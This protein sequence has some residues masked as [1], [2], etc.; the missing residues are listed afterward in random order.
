[1]RT[2]IYNHKNSKIVGIRYGLGPQKVICLHGYGEDAQKFAFLEESLGNKF[3]F[4]CINLPFHGETNWQSTDSLSPE[5][6]NGI[7]ENIIENDSENAPCYLLGYSLGGRIAL[8]LYQ[9][10][11]K[12]YSKLILLAPDGFT[13]NPWYWLA[14]QTN[15][16]NKLFQHTMKNPRWF[17]SLAKKLN[18]WKLINDS[19]FKFAHYY[20]DDENAREALYKRWT[21][22]KSFKPD[23]DKIKR[24]V[25]ENKTNI[26]L[27]YGRFDR[28]ILPKKG[29]QFC[30]EIGNLGSLT[31]I[32]AGHQLL[33]EKSLEEISK[34]LISFAILP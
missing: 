7:I 1:M 29:E 6:L 16:G 9:P 8:S 22:L 28:I 15:I 19:V 33:N 24:L 30:K 3:S 32:P 23:L 26:F 27:L 21:I 34:A 13:V 14:T 18:Q 20:I 12:K 5:E 4:Y 25:K 11:P 17:F 2:I 31:I 10:N